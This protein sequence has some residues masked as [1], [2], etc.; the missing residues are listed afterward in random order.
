MRDA[1]DRTRGRL[2][3]GNQDLSDEVG[4]G[5]GSG[6]VHI[7]FDVEVVYSDCI[8]NFLERAKCGGQNEFAIT[9]VKGKSQCHESFCYFAAGATSM[10][11]IG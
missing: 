4:F 9:I 5:S 3:S 7:V 8:E 1:D 6:I 2:R 11:S 10:F